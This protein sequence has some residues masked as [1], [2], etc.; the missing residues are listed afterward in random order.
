MEVETRLRELRIGRGMA[1]AKLAGVVGVSRQTIYAIEDGSYLPNTALALRLARALEVRVEDLFALPP[2]SGETEVHVTAELL[3]EESRF[4]RLCE[5]HGRIMAAPAAPVPVYLPLADGV[6]RSS[7]GRSASVSLAARPER[8]KQ[9]L[10]A[11]C[12]PALSLLT[13]TLAPSGF[14]I[15]NAPASSR[16]A[17]QWLKEGKVHAAGAHLRDRRTGE[18]NVPIVRRLFPG[19]AVRMITFAAWEEGL[20]FRSG[21]PKHI[22]SIADLARPDVR[23]VNREKGSGSRD[24]LDS[25]LAAAGVAPTSVQ[26]YRDIA[27]GHLAAALSVATGAAD[28]CVATRSAARCFGLDFHPLSTER[29]DLAIASASLQLPAV[30]TLLDTLNRSTLRKQLHTFAGYDTSETGKVLV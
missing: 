9:I 4:V 1:A 11:G 27:Q 24:L 22:G 7:A 18:Y 25:G 3:S 23:I 28:C 17:L 29:F 16:R 20:V 12:D 30:Q 8:G 26:G 15:V 14:E 19:D 5:V 13:K 21:N 2:E 10:L 6:V